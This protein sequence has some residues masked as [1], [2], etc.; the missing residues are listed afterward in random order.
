MPGLVPGIHVF[1][2][3]RVCKTWMAGTSPAM[4]EV[5]FR[6]YIISDCG[7]FAIF[8]VGK[9]ARLEKNIRRL[10]TL[11]IRVKWRLRI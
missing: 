5:C 3:L 10:S 1:S 6:Q 8:R 7:G 4:A 2:F 11:K 9:N